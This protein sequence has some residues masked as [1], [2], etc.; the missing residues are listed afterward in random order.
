MC[1]NKK[2]LYVTCKRKSLTQPYSM[3]YVPLKV[4]YNFIFYIV[5]Q[6]EDPPNREN[7]TG[8]LVYIMDGYPEDYICGTR[9]Y[10]TD[11]PII[12]G[13]LDISLPKGKYSIKQICMIYCLEF[14]V[15]VGLRTKTK[16][17]IGRRDLRYLT[18]AG[19]EFIARETLNWNSHRVPN[20]RADSY[21]TH[22]STKR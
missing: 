19:M 22:C 3:S 11:I 14:P 9:V 15:G 2:K 4:S 1:Y 13:K 16:I 10:L 6:K 7:K 21:P 18:L 8:R 17:E 20:I 12:G 5:L